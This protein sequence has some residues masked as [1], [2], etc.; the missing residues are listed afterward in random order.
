MLDKVTNKKIIREAIDIVLKLKEGGF[1]NYDDAEGFCEWTIKASGL[2]FAYFYGYKE[3]DNE[4][5]FFNDSL[6]YYEDELCGVNWFRDN[7]GRIREVF[8]YYNY[9]Y[10]EDNLWTLTA[11]LW[12]NEIGEEYAKNIYERDCLDDP[13]YQEMGDI[14][15]KSLMELGKTV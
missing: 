6:I 10:D 3:Y 7:I 15:K 13:Y 4:E 8:E 14:I 11:Y 12:Q 1:V 2:S 9:N 5:E